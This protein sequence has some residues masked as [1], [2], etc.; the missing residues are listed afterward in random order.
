LV[1]ENILLGRD[2]GGGGGGRETDL[3]G[4]TDVVRGIIHSFLS[5][6]LSSFHA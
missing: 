3:L 4:H 1:S 6:L 5:F 2:G